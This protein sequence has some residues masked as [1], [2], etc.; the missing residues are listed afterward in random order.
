[1][2]TFICT[3]I[4]TGLIVFTTAFPSQAAPGYQRYRAI[5]GPMAPCVATPGMMSQEMAVPGPRPGMQTRGRFSM[6]CR[7][8]SKRGFDRHGMGAG[9]GLPE[10]RQMMGPDRDGMM[11]LSPR[12]GRQGLHH[13]L[14]LDR[15]ED[16]GLTPEQTAKLKAVHLDCRKEQI[17]KG[18]EIRIARLELADLLDQSTWIPAAAEK[19]IRK[20][21]TLAG[22][23][24]I[25]Q[26][27][28][29]TEAS[30]VLT[31]EQRKKA[32][33]RGDASDPACLFR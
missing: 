21:H 30:A 33:A 27:E 12:W 3:C 9:Q 5:G 7:M 11:E 2:R 18:A 10:R 6:P 31:P 29:V 14:F 32:A 28:A 24:Q 8:E 25:R 13:M 16:L 15:V 17:R 22:D 19:L 20:I 23:L 4:L 26:L 1:M